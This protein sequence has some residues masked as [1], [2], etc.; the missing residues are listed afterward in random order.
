MELKGFVFY[1]EALRQIVNE[2]GGG[3]EQKLS[4]VA[5]RIKTTAQTNLS[6]PYAGR[7]SRNPAPGPPKRRTGDLVESVVVG[8]VTY[9]DDGLI[10]VPV[11]S[12]AV[13]R[14]FDYSRWLRDNSY[15]FI[16]PEQMIE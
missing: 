1:P 5:G 7:G 13:H 14:G 6:D 15:E 12:T 16:R 3:I 9:G 8:S 4:G 11:N 2:P 10:V